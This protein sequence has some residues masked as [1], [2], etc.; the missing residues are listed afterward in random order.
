MAALDFN[1]ALDVKASEV[2]PIP[3]PPT[4]HYVWQVTRVPEIQDGDTWQ[5]VNFLCQ[6]VS[7]FEDTDDV[8]RDELKAFG[9]ITSIQNRVSF[10]FNKVEG[11]EADL[12]TFQNRMKRFMVDHLQAGGED[13]SL[14]QLMNASVNK[15]FIGQLTHRQDKNDPELLRANIG[16]TA[17]LID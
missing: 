1:K 2:A 8:D 4:G 17:P 14:R 12:V 15:R 11:T 9:K 6:A 10:M 7:V 16:R 3:V 5:S 13:M